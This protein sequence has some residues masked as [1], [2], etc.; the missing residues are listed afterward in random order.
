MKKT[1]TQWIKRLYNM[2]CLW[3][4]GRLLSGARTKQPPTIKL[5]SIEDFTIEDTLKAFYVLLQRPQ[6]KGKMMILKT[7]LRDIV[8]ENFAENIKIQHIGNPDAYIISVPKK[9]EPKIILATG[10]NVG[11][12]N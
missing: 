9:E 8:P 5:Q 3:R 7:V 10:E 6:N 2:F 11:T 12:F 4:V 1:L